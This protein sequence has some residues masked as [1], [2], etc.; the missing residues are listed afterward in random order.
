MWC[1]MEFANAVALRAARFVAV[2][3][4]QRCGGWSSCYRGG[5]T[6]VGGGGCGR[7]RVGWT[8]WLRWAQ[9]VETAAGYQFLKLSSSFSDFVG[10]PET[11]AQLSHRADLQFGNTSMEMVTKKRT[12][13]IASMSVLLLLMLCRPSHQQSSEP[14]CDC[15][16]DCYLGCKHAFPMLCEVLCGGSCDERNDPVAACMIAC[17]TDS[18]CG[19]PAAPSG[20]ADC[21]H[22]CNVTWGRH[23]PAKVP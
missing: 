23:G 4:G 9:S 10:S 19:V 7:L 6:V 22:A 5:A 21:S 11:V 12:A 1:A 8:R 20:A 15:Y 14:S 13:V 17:T 2:V 16:R 3:C 18:L